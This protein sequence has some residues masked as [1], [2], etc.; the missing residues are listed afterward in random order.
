[1][2]KQNK[3]YFEAWIVMRVGKNPTA[4]KVGIYYRYAP[5]WDNLECYTIFPS[6]KAAYLWR[7]H[8]KNK[9]DFDIFKVKIP[10]I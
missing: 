3:N 5:K 10:N 2:K 6:K 1:M 4:E 8:W 9:E 7:N